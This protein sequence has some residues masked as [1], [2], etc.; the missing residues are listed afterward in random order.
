MGAYPTLAGQNNPVGPQVSFRT[1]SI[2]P[3]AALYVGPSDQLEFEARCPSTSSALALTVRLLTPQGIIEEY[4]ASYTVATAGTAVFSALMT[5][6]EGFVLSAH[7]HGDAVSRG[8]CFCKLHLRKNPTGTDLVLGA[9]LFQGYVSAD[10]HLS[11]PQSPTESSLNGRGWLRAILGTPPGAGNSYFLQV[12]AGVRWQVR[13]IY[14]GVSTDVTAGSRYLICQLTDSA[15]HL[16]GASPNLVAQ[17]ASQLRFYTWAFAAA[18]GTADL[19]SINPLPGDALLPSGFYLAL[20]FI[21]LGP[22]DAIQAVYTLVEEWV[23]Q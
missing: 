9:L 4:Q 19:Y 5:P 3:P 7:L 11:Y 6:A 8:Q 18:Q 22:A 20:N 14:A 17:T 1:Q 12:P 16:V 13:S 23:A 21:S 2:L 10:D 15:F